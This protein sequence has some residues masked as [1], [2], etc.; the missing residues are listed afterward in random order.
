M[1]SPID[2]SQ[3]AA[4]RKS[5][6]TRR[7][8]KI[9]VFGVKIPARPWVVTCFTTLLILGALGSVTLK[10]IIPMIEERAALSKLAE[11]K[12]NKAAS[13]VRVEQEKQEKTR[14]P[15]QEYQKHFW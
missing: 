15:F 9:E 4:K 11:A 1:A 13:D 3:A 5:L 12:S 10:L 7:K 14:D 8:S 6:R 2:S